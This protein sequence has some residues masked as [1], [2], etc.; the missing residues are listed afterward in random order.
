[1]CRALNKTENSSGGN[2]TT[3]RT[4]WG[5]DREGDWGWVWGERVTEG[6]SWLLALNKVDEGRQK[7]LDGLGLLPP[8]AG[9]IRGSVSGSCLQAECFDQEFPWWLSGNKQTTIHGDAGL[10]PGLT[11]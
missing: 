1:M 5:E 10:I 9:R 4:A 2:S 8:G 3:K 7:P 11:W 6:P